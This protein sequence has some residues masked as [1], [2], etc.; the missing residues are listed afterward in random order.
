MPLLSNDEIQDIADY[1]GDSLY[2]SQVA[3]KTDAD[4]IVFVE[5]IL[6]QKQQKY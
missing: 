5:F 4:I 6:W 2:L 3:M 1:L